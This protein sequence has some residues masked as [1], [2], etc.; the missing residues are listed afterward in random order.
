VEFNQV[1]T[2]STG[3]PSTQPACVESIVGVC[4]HASDFG[5]SAGGRAIGPST[6]GAGV[7]GGAVGGSA[8]TGDSHLVRGLG[9]LTTG[10]LRGGGGGQC[11]PC[12]SSPGGVDTL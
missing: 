1:T 4:K 12:N 9:R 3:Q 2:F 5:A 8:D 10:L 11:T 6:A 7:V